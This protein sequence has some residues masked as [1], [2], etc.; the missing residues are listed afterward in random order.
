MK[1]M[2]YHWY[3]VTFDPYGTYSQRK[4]STG[5]VKDAL[6][7]FAH[8]VIIEMNKTSINEPTKMSS[9]GSTRKAKFCS[10]FYT[11]SPDKIKIDKNIYAEM[12]IVNPRILINE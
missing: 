9:F 6:I 4:T 3:Q 12:P 10:H 2:V 5:F 8:I 11:K 7:D 1:A